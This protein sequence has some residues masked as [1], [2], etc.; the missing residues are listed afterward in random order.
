MKATLATI[1]T[2][3]PASRAAA[4]A[5]A[6]RLTSVIGNRAMRVALT[7]TN[8]AIRAPLLPARSVQLEPSIGRAP[9]GPRSHPARASGSFTIHADPSYAGNPMRDSRTPDDAEVRHHAAHGVMGPWEALPHRATIET[10][11]GRDLSHVRAHVGGAAAE[12]ARAIGAEAYATGNSVAFSR[13]PSLHTAAHEAAHVVQQAA[14]VRL[15]GGVGR[16][17]DEYERNADAVADRVVA[18]ASVA[19]L[20]PGGRSDDD[21]SGIAVTQPKRSA[22]PVQRAADPAPSPYVNAEGKPNLA[23]VQNPMS[24]PEWP[25]FQSVMAKYGISEALAGEQWQ[26]ICRGLEL[27]ATGGDGEAL[28]R[29]VTDWMVETSG[30]DKFQKPALWAGWPTGTVAQECGF[31]PLRDAALGDA[32]APLQLFDGDFQ[33]QMRPLWV[34]ISRA[35]ADQLHGDIHV[36][37]AKFATDSI[38]LTDELPI[39]RQR[40]LDGWVGEIIFHAIDPASMPNGDTSHPI[41]LDAAGRPAGSLHPLKSELEVQSALQKR[42]AANAAGAK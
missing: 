33:T 26:K 7:G 31:N 23:A 21:A 30:I 27:Q 17:G 38:V 22:E 20:L 40:Q 4:P 19:D 28:F 25:T 15:L 41:F 18:G 8:A 9:G 3:A 11:F 14:G 32:L 42:A 13:P 6:R 1:A 16:A 39:I 12:S 36:F 5:T 34:A 35:F 2:G 29:E 10:L 37:M 24:H